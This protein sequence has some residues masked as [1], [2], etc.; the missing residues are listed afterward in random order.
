MVRAT[1]SVFLSRPLRVC[2][3]GEIMDRLWY[4][5]TPDVYHIMAKGDWTD[6]TS[7]ERFA[8]M[9]WAYVDREAAQK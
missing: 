4:V 1:D 9:R 3:K 2:D 6:Y 5:V 8:M 7:F